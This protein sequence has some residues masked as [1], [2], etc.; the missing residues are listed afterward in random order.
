MKKGTL[1]AAVAAVA[2]M[3]VGASSAKAEPPVLGP[4]NNTVDMRVVNNYPWAVSVY[5]QDAHGRTHY[6]GQ[7]RSSELKILE[8]PGAFAAMGDVSIEIFPSTPARS[9]FDENPGVKTSKIPLKIGDAVNVVVE[10][11]LL[12]T[13]VEHEKG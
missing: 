2:L 3:G 7:V 12:K 6:M 4:R 9:F 8:I 5:V 10:S 13:R 1:V 11:S